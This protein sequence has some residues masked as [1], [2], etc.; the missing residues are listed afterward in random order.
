MSAVVPDLHGVSFGKSLLSLTANSA[1]CLEGAN[2][3]VCEGGSSLT[4][5]TCTGTNT[6]T[7]SVL[8]YEKKFTSKEI[9]TCDGKII[10]LKAKMSLGAG[11]SNDILWAEKWRPKTFFDLVGNEKTNRFILRWLRRWSK[12]VFDEKVIPENVKKSATLQG[13]AGSVGSLKPVGSAGSVKPI[14]SNGS[15]GN[16]VPKLYEVDP[17]DR[18]EKKILLIHGPPGIGKTSVVHI[19][20][21]QAGY[22]I[23]EINASDERAGQ[24]VK[25]KIIN[26]L[27]TQTFSGKPICLVCD[28]IDDNSKLLMRPIICICNDLFAHSLEKLRPF[29]EIVSFK[30]P[31]ERTV[32]ERLRK[33]CQEEKI[34]IDH[35]DLNDIVSISNCD[36]RSCLNL[37]QFGI[38]N[39][40]DESRKKD[41]QI[42][43]FTIVKEIFQRNPKQIKKQQFENLQKIVIT[44]GNYDKV[45]NG[46]F[47]L[48]HDVEYQDDL[49]SKP[50]E[51]GDWLYFHDIM[52]K[53]SYNLQ[54]L[55]LASYCGHV[56]MKFF[57]SFSDPYNREKQLKPKSDYE[58]YEAKRSNLDLQKNLLNNIQ[59][60]TIKSNLNVSI[61]STQLLPYLS[62]ILTPNLKSTRHN[63]KEL[64][65]NKV[66]CAIATIKEFGFR[67]ENK[68]DEN[69]IYYL[70]LSPPIDNM[71]PFSEASLKQLAAKRLSMYPFFIE[72]LSKLN[73]LKRKRDVTDQDKENKNPKVNNNE[74]KFVNS[75]DFFKNKY[76]DFSNVE[77]TS[78]ESKP[79]KEEATRIWVKYNEGFSNAVRKNITWR[80]LWET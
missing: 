53:S 8:C 72:Q 21:K 71:I 76:K 36:I 30:K 23:M 56:P 4:T 18:P 48:Y 38:S 29:A 3:D 44:S 61:L 51:I 6:S 12:A 41:F 5:G 35:K 16:M 78:N 62:S 1:E 74:K 73:T 7:Q 70:T 31:L 66:D 15:M 19:V 43:W 75:A 39:N 64:E 58:F 65:R 42:N 9:I 27:S 28:E 14:G 37:L 34:K 22:E 80:E 63:I 68:K 69:G 47:S 45:V 55:A 25:D 52:Y 57:N 50:D 59:S 26:S 54:N 2:T 46:C 32:K 10:K 67:I 13:P 20:A 33:I 17:F 60:I 77:K 11:A 49:L 79:H 40:D 24:R